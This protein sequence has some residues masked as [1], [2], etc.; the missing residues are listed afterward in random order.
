MGTDSRRVHSRYQRRLADATV[1]GR[2]VVVEL[3]VRRLFCDAAHCPRRT[4]A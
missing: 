1:G 3:S 2:P 4:F